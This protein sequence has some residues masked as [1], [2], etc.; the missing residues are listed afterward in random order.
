[1]ALTRKQYD[2]ISKKLR[3]Y[4]ANAIPDYNKVATALGVPEV[5]VMGVWKGSI[6]RPKPPKKE[7]D[8]SKLHGVRQVDGRTVAIGGRRLR[9][10][11]PTKCARCNRKFFLLYEGSGMCQACQPEFERKQAREYL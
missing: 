1:M 4:Q 11:A 3:D 2:G 5:T 6:S 9:R 10:S 7:I 8:A